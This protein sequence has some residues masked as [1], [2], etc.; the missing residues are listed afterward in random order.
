MQPLRGVGLTVEPLMILGRV[1]SSVPFAERERF[2]YPEPLTDSFGRSMP[3]RSRTSLRRT[4]SPGIAHSNLATRKPK[5]SR[6]ARSRNWRLARAIDAL[7]AP[8]GLVAPIDRRRRLGLNWVG[9]SLLASLTTMLLEDLSRGRALQ[10]QCGQ[11]F[12]SSAYQA[13]YCSR[14]CRWRFEQRKFRKGRL[15]HKRWDC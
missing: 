14:Q 10:C 1:F 13:T 15:A 2:A 12:V 11:L 7:V 9:N 8:T 6:F 5:T 4:R 3:S